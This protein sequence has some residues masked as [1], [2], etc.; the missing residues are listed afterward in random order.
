[1]GKLLSSDP[2][3]TVVKLARIFWRS[4]RNQQI[5]IISKMPKST[6]SDSKTEKRKSDGKGSA[7]PKKAKKSEFTKGTYVGKDGKYVYDGT[8]LNTD[9]EVRIRDEFTEPMPK[10]NSDGFL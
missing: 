9:E 2:Q 6:K 4:F 1:M 10:K 3:K 7:E 8:I 5:F